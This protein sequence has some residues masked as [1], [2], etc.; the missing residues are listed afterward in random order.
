[1]RILVVDD[2]PSIR[3]WADLVLREQ[4]YAVDVARDAASG[5]GL[6]LA[7]SYDLAI[8]DLDLPDRSGLALVYALREAGRHHPVLIMTGTDDEDAIVAALDAG[9]DDYLI[10]PV[11]SGILRA[12]VRAALRRGGNRVAQALHLGNLRVEPAERRVLVGRDVV[13]LTAREYD[14]LAFLLQ[15]S[16][17]L[18][19]R[20]ELL[21]RVWNMRFDTQTNVVEA[22]LSRLRRKLRDAGADVTVRAVRGRGYIVSVLAPA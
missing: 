7:M 6:G 21:E 3:D 1:M 11:S 2:D 20:S 9:A 12:R 17:L 14:V 22:T 10:K 8:L 4:G 18:V 15:R 16:G 13:M 5:R 19:G